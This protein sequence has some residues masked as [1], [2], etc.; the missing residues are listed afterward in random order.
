MGRAPTAVN[1]GTQNQ[2]AWA[3]GEGVDLISSLPNTTCGRTRVPCAP[4]WVLYG[5]V[6]SQLPQSGI[7]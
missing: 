3:G 2:F 4:S 5:S 6:R 1:G 7:S